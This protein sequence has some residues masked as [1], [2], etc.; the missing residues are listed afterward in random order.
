MPS[1]QRFEEY[2]D[3]I[4]N[5]VER[6]GD[7]VVNEIEGQTEKGD[8]VQGY[9]C[10]HGDHTYLVMV[11]PGWEHIAIRYEYSVD[12]LWYVHNEI[13]NLPEKEEVQLSQEELKTARRNLETE[14]QNYPDVEK[15]EMRLNLKQIL[16]REGCSVQFDTITD[17]LNVH[18]FY[19]DKKVFHQNEEVHI[20]KFEKAVQNVI[21]FGW[22]AKDLIAEYY[23][24]TSI[25]TSG[26]PN[27]R[28]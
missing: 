16:S 11:S 6:I 9:E 17:S 24:L 28:A 5:L 7:E 25:S 14:L 20:G 3:Q 8:R 23:G 18:G 4:V 1:A 19:V 10:L 26:S 27:F 22:T 2:L 21:N 15:R 13:R 12:G